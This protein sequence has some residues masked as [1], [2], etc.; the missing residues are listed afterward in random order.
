MATTNRSPKS[1]IW[2]TEWWSMIACHGVALAALFGV[3][4]Q[5]DVTGL[6]DALSKAIGGAAIFLANA[7]VVVRYM[8]HRTLLKRL[9][10]LPDDE[11][12]TGPS[13]P[14]PLP[15][16][17]ACLFLAAAADPATAAPAITRTLARTTSDAPQIGLL[18]FGFGRGQQPAVPQAPLAPHVS[19]QPDPAIGQA[20]Q[21]LA[22][23]H[24]ALT[25]ALAAQARPQGGCNGNCCPCPKQQPGQPQP[26]VI[27][28]LP[29][30]PPLQQT[31]PA[32]SGGCP[33]QPRPGQQSV[34]QAGPA[35]GYSPAPISQ[36]YNPAPISQQYHPAPINQGYSPQPIS[37]G[38]NPVPIQIHLHPSAPGAPTMP[39]PASPPGSYNPQP[40]SSGPPVPAP[41]P[42]GYN[43]A[44]PRA[45]GTAIPFGFQRY[46]TVR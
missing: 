18:N 32:V 5:G 9:H 3:V 14:P 34:P 8:G 37:Q 1:G 15:V 10:L 36:Q 33:C 24:A 23:S 6:N 43:P 27:N 41:P 44:P 16:I 38:Y 4:A 31:P 13:G 19:V 7:W 28:V 35:Q 22:Q 11:E 21:Q 26:Q 40:P 45:T 25:A 2:T 39:A 42:G 29:A 46:T 30:Q 20:L 17:L 12:D